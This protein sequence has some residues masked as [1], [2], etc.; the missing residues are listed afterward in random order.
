[1]QEQP[2]KQGQGF[3]TMG[4][5]H[6]PEAWPAGPGCATLAPTHLV[7]TCMQALMLRCRTVTA[8]AHMDLVLCLLPRC[9]RPEGRHQCQWLYIPTLL[10]TPEA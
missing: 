1:M 5:G 4:F 6:S 9:W 2:K 3:V 8:D 10:E 7:F